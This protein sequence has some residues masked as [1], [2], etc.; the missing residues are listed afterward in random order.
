MTEPTYEMMT[1]DPERYERVDLPLF[2]AEL[3]DFLPDTVHDFHVHVNLAQYCPE[4]SEE[5][6]RT[7]WPSA[8]P[9]HF[10]AEHMMD[11]QRKLFPERKTRSLAFASPSPDNN[12]MALNSYLSR[13]AAQSPEMD[14]L[15][16]ARPYESP[17][18]VA[19]KLKQG[20]FLG[21]KP[22]MGL[23]SHIADVNDV[24]I[25]DYFPPA[26][27][28]LAHELGL[29]VMLHIPGLERLRDPITHADLRR[30]SGT[31][32]NMK[33]CIAHIGRAYTVSYGQPGLE[34]LQDIEGLYYDF[35]AN[36]NEDV[37]ELALRMV[38]PDRLLYG[39]D[40]PIL[41]M[42]GVREY[43]GDRYINFTDA[44]Y[45]WNTN[46]KPA[47]VEANYT[48]YVYEQLLSFK[49]AAL[50]VGLSS[51]QVARVMHGNADDLVASVSL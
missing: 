50:K 14:A 42:R 33:L 31:Y 1:I 2:R 22:Y 32:P 51:E 45:P 28:Q 9:R 4:P 20:G 12:L 40:L 3:D 15:Y 18:S 23:A 6:K 38:G 41:L 21:L 27:Q 49:R 17:E 39:S 48:F 19:E 37:I 34:A 47:E 29:I 44:D 35:S 36:P 43:D 8:I 46:R 24:R 5:T 11:I 7:N 26:H 30:I 13:A 25:D 16:V 10:P